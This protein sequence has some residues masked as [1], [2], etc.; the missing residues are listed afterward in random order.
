L[1]EKYQYRTGILCDIYRIRA[2]AGARK[3]I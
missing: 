3:E 2:S 1:S